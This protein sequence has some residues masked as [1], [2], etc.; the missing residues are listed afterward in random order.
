M[1][2]NEL[3]YECNG[4][5]AEKFLDQLTQTDMLCICCVKEELWFISTFSELTPAK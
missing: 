4:C 2:G 5:G 3:T 1:I